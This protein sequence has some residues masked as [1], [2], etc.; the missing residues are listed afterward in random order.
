MRSPKSG[1]KPKGGKNRSR[2]SLSSRDAGLVAPS[3]DVSNTRNLPE[4]ETGSPSLHG[5]HID[6]TRALEDA[7][8]RNLTGF[9]KKNLTINELHELQKSVSSKSAGVNALNN[10]TDLLDYKT[11]LSFYKRMDKTPAFFLTEFLKT[12][13]ITPAEMPRLISAILR[14]VRDFKTSALDTTTQ[15]TD[16]SQSELAS[17]KAH[18]LAHPWVPRSGIT[19]SAH[20]AKY[21]K[22]W[23]KRG[24]KREHIVE[25]QPNLAAGYAT[26]ISR[27][28]ERRVK[29][30]ANAPLEKLP[31]GAPRPLSTRPVIELSD[32]EKEVR[33]QKDAA[34][35]RRSRANQKARQGPPPSP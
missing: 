21:F 17:F 22:K 24:L 2:E 9:R 28:P 32:A 11:P 31:A 5:R 14:I 35:K 25:A 20:I 27:Y 4:N 16:L 19:P 6:N 33:R 10:R 3:S 12:E 8:D 18:A 34:K 13:G 26:E 29:G 23:L 7:I 1:D 15:N 30:I